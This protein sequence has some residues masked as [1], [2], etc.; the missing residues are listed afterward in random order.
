[1]VS[2]LATACTHLQQRAHNCYSIETLATVCTYLPQLAHVTGTT[3]S[4]ILPG[5]SPGR[6]EQ[7][8]TKEQDPRLRSP[9]RCCEQLVYSAPAIQRSWLRSLVSMATKRTNDSANNRN[10]PLSERGGSPEPI[11]ERGGSPDLGERHPGGQWCSD[12]SRLR[13]SEN[14]AKSNVPMAGKRA[15]NS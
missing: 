3:G 11:N 9:C 10:G 7:Q 2:T 15:R 14:P 12:R 4:V 6:T 13:L 1:M 5:K 8:H